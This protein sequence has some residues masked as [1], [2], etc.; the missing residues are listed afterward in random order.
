MNQ[1]D[2]ETALREHLASQILSVCTQWPDP[3][4]LPLQGSNFIFNVQRPGLYVGADTYVAV[5][6]ATGEVQVLRS[7]E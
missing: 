4:Y 2:A 7:G 5:N 3:L 1:Q 6:A